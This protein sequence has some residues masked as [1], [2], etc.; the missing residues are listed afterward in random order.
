MATLTGKKPAETYKDLLQVSNANL[1]IDATLRVV[2]DGEGTAS[3][4]YLASGKLKIEPSADATDIVEIVESDGTTVLVRI[5]TTNGRVVYPQLTP[6][7]IAKI[8][9]NNE[10]TSGDLTDAELPAVSSSSAGAAPSTSGASDGDV[11][12]VQAD[13]SVAYE[14]GGGSAALD[15][16]AIYVSKTGNDSN[17]GLNMDVPKLTISAAITAAD[18]AYG[19][20]HVIDAGTYAEGVTCVDDITLYAPNATIDLGSGGDQLTLAGQTTVVRQ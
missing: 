9:S 2:E 4:L 17:D 14:V 18:G 10:L 15:Q 1:G 7:K 19:L 6:S 8:G 16:Q 11:L 3:P 20:V 13:G 12:T 5:D